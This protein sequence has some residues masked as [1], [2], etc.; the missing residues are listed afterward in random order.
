MCRSFRPDVGPWPSP[1][2]VEARAA[3]FEEFLEV[4]DGFRRPAKL[5]L[6]HARGSNL[7]IMPEP[8]STIHT[9]SFLSTRTECA[10][11]AA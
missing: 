3:V 5:L 8:S 4:I 9:L 10:K 11:D 6:G 7:M 1:G 2:V